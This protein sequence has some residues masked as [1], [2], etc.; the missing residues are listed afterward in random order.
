M[1]TFHAPPNIHVFCDCLFWNRALTTVCLHMVP[2]SSSKRTPIPP[3]FCVFEV[4]IKLLL[5]SRAHFSALIFQKCSERESHLPFWLEIRALATV[6]H[7]CWQLP[8]IEVRNRE[9]R[10]PKLRR[11]HNPHYPQNNWVSQ[12]RF[13]TWIHTLPNCMLL[14]SIL[15]LAHAHCSCSP[16]CWHDD[17]TASGHLSVTWKF[18][19]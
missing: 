14:F 10:H 5:Q 7:F 1:R 16:C 3:L 15:L 13:H 9:N 2:T 12:G 18:P 11:P 17:K 8:Q 19:N 6:L 4:H